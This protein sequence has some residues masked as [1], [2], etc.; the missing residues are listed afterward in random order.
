[1]QLIT[2]KRWTL[3]VP[4]IGGQVISNEPNFSSFLFPFSLF[5]MPESN[6][7]R[8]NY[9]NSHNLAIIDQDNILRNFTQV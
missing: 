1:M 8:R 6:V 7:C 5:H 9:R 2:T 4:T 3:E